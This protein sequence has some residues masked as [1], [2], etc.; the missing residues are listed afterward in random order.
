MTHPFK[1]VALAF[2][3]HLRY[4]NLH[5]PNDVMLPLIFWSVNPC[6]TPPQDNFHHLRQLKSEIE[7]LQHLLNK[8]REKIQTDFGPWYETALAREGHGE[9]KGGN[10]VAASPPPLCPT[11]GPYNNGRGQLKD[12]TGNNNNVSKSPTCPRM[13]LTGN[14]DTDEDIKVFGDSI[15]SG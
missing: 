13:L 3:P 14:E 5:A 8:S 1:R 2:S 15:Y 11:A 12:N 6:S 7:L 10:T 4:C 9:E